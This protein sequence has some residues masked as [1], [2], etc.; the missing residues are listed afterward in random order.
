MDSVYLSA[1]TSSSSSV[2]RDLKQTRTA[3]PTSAACKKILVSYHLLAYLYFG[4][5]LCSYFCWNVVYSSDSWAKR[6]TFLSSWNVGPVLRKAWE[7][8]SW[9]ESRPAQTSA[10][11]QIFTCV[12]VLFCF[13]LPN[14]LSPSSA[15]L[16]KGPNS[17]IIQTYLV[18]FWLQIL[19]HIYLFCSDVSDTNTFQ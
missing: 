2:I 5:P 14:L 8:S 10:S 4:H 16:L 13:V 17:W 11:F 18:D 6:W 9:F 15:V 1:I 12:F 19:C 7:W 3:I